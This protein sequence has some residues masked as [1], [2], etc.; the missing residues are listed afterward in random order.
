MKTMTIKAAN[1]LLRERSK[2]SG[3]TITFMEPQLD[4]KWHCGSSGDE[5]VHD[6]F[7]QSQGPRTRRI[8]GAYV[9]VNERYRHPMGGW[10]TLYARA[11]AFF[12]IYGDTKRDVKTEMTLDVVNDVLR[13]SGLEIL[14]VTVVPRSN[15]PSQSPSDLEDAVENYAP[16]KADT[17]IV[18]KTVDYS[19]DAG[20]TGERVQSHL[21]PVIYARTIEN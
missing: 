7:L 15:Y 18:G 4:S 14:K 10:E 11:I 8:D 5:R 20:S 9:S 1:Q 3:S 21:T 12:N 13:P 19:Y 2:T 17:C 16:T 6:G